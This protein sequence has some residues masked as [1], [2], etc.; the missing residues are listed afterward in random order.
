MRIAQPEIDIYAQVSLGRPLI[1][2][3][4]PTYGLAFGTVESV[5]KNYG[6]KYQELENCIKFTAP[7]SRL[8]YF[9]EKLHFGMVPYNTKPF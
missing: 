9:I 7:K 5:A 8:Q 3:R 1:D 2:R 6:I 4:V